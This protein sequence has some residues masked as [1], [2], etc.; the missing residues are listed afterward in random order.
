VTASEP[1]SRSS[2]DADHGGRWACGTLGRA[3]GLTGELYLDPLPRGVEYL[4]AGERFYV[5][6]EGGGDVPPVRL[7]RSGG[8]DR[9]PLVR[10]EGVD[11]V[12]AAKALTGSLV[13]AAGETLDEGEFFTVSELVGLRAVC[14]ETD[15]GV[16]TDL[17]VNPAHDILEIDPAGAGGGEAGHAAS[18][19]ADRVLVP[20]V[21]ELVD[22]D[23]DEGVVRVREGLLEPP[24]K[25]DGGDAG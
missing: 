7:W 19:A 11:S 12:D 21:A 20:F 8:T 3:H 18:R 4:A 14:G 6:R 10:V 23:L 1:S 2:T 22:V 5:T 25:G 15:L 9:R 24:S 13:F 16:V 17:L